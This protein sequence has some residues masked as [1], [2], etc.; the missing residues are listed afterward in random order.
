MLRCFIQWYK[1][2]PLST[3]VSLLITCIPELVFIMESQNLLIEPPPPPHV[4]YI[5]LISIGLYGAPG[6]DIVYP[7]IMSLLGADLTY[8]RVPSHIRQC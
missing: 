2:F 8:I 1:I 6:S 4:T 3:I 7:Y 5:A